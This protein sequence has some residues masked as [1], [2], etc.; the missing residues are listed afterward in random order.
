[1]ALLLSFEAAAAI[2]KINVIPVVVDGAE[3]AVG[4]EGWR[5]RGRE[6]DL[7]LVGGGVVVVSRD[8]DGGGGVGRR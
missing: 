3:G 5:G 8:N 2:A 1:L 6:T 7:W 4:R